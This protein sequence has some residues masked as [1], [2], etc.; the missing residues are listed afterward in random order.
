MFFK[1]KRKYDDYIMNKSFI[2]NNNILEIF[3]K[4]Y[5][6]YLNNLVKPDWN[7]LNNFEQD[8]GINLITIINYLKKKKLKYSL[9]NEIEEKDIKI[10][11]LEILNV[12]GLSTDRLKNYPLEKINLIDN[13][14]DEGFLHYK[15]A[16]NF[17]LSKFNSKNNWTISLRVVARIS[18]PGIVELSSKNKTIEEEGNESSHLVVFE[19]T[20]KEV[21]DLLLVHLKDYE[22][23]IEHLVYGTWKMSDCDGFMDGNS[24]FRKG[25]KISF[26][27]DF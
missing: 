5:I 26:I 16:D 13:K 17:K 11:I 7:Q 21:E 10:E 25:E 19:H 20:F 18:H 4:L 27:E 3:K 23:L 1:K 6:T 8:F 24:L 2:E 22:Q 12:C 15:F 14:Y 9:K